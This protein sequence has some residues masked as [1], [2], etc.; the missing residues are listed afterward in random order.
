VSEGV[1]EKIALQGITQIDAT[2]LLNWMP[3]IELQEIMNLLAERN[4]IKQKTTHI[5]FVF[6]INQ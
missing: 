2:D 1:S 3:N 6:V 4:V 5:V